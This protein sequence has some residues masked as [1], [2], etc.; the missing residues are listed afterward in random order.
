M[1]VGDVFDIDRTYDVNENPEPNLLFYGRYKITRVL[2]PN[3]AYRVCPISPTSGMMHEHI[4]YVIKTGWITTMEENM[5]ETERLFGWKL[6]SMF[7]NLI[8][9]T[10]A[11]ITH[12]N[13]EFVRFMYSGMYSLHEML[14]KRDAFT[15]SQARFLMKEAYAG[16]FQIAF[17]GYS[18][19]GD[20]NSG[21]VVILQPRRVAFIDFD[22]MGIKDTETDMFTDARVRTRMRNVSDSSL[23]MG[24]FNVVRG[25]EDAT[26]NVF[27][28]TFTI[29]A[30]VDRLSR[31]MAEDRINLDRKPATPIE[32]IQRSYFML[33]WVFGYEERLAFYD[34]KHDKDAMTEFIHGVIYNVARDRDFENYMFDIGAYSELPFLNQTHQ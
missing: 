26:V 20:Y 17:L 9:E 15:I 21:N 6:F 7:P 2:R 31:C 10:Q 22:T 25:V 18:A 5:R 3:V 30:F 1:N 11:R 29:E 24:M 14:D 33:L 28:Q 13:E 23:R 27:G 4:Q 12:P 8:R 19:H 32:H 34:K 16:L